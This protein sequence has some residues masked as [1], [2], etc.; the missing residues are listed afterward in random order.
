MF[1]CLKFICIFKYVICSD[2]L[3]KKGEG[4]AKKKEGQPSSDYLNLLLK[5]SRYYCKF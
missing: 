5:I 3:T 1:I 4:S 2:G